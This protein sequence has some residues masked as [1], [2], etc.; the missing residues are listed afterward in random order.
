MK[1]KLYIEGGGSSPTQATQF[2]EAWKTFFL[3]AGIDRTLTAVRGGSRNDTFDDYR[4]AVRIKRPDELPLLLVD[5]EDL[6]TG[7][8]TEWQHL[9]MRDNW[10]KPSGAGDQ[11]AFLMVCCMETWFLADREALKRFFHGCWRDNALPQ[12]PDLEKVPKADV[13]DKL[14][15]ATDACGKKEYAKGKRSFEI[16]KAI[17]PAK[18]E[19][20]CP[21]AKRLLDR[22]RNP[23]AISIR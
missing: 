2:R 14:A 23:H 21:G 11:D 10:N 6:V 7:G 5:S 17:N 9:K 16:L 4:T 3:K 18:V 22:L 15:A 8:N 20:K 13:F 19:K 12:W 1:I